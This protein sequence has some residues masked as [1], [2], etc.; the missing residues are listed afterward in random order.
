MVSSEG[1][2]A[3]IVNNYSKMSFNFGP[4]LLSWMEKYSP[5]TLKGIQEAD[6]LS[7]ER[8]SGH[9]SA[10]AQVYNHIIMPLASD[11][12][13]ETQIKW[14]I[15]D[16][17][18]RFNRDPEGMWL[19]E[20][21]VDTDTLEIL[22]E[23][24]IKFTVLAPRQAKEIKEIEDDEWLEVNEGNL[25]T[26][27]AYLCELPSGRTINLFFYDGSISQSIA[28]GG[29]LE[30]GQ[31]LAENLVDAFDD[32]QDSQLVHIATDG[33]SYGHHHHNGDMAMAYCM[34]Y[35]EKNDLAKITNYGEFL[36]KNPPNFQ[37]KI[38]ENSSW[39]CSH[40]VERW[41][42]DCGCNA[43]RAGWNQEW[44]KPLREA[45][46]FLRDSSLEIFEKNGSKY[47]K[48]PREA[49]NA[50]IEIILD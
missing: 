39:S 42:N 48:D 34:D 12:D 20:T 47:L 45:L 21:A 19:A 36:E 50:Y 15:K 35:I 16:F 18:K 3:D 46:D 27:V 22:A 38:N 41:R 5:D 29:L 23:N 11:L 32:N 40:G 33:E 24:N 14:G 43:G 1:K 13:K 17:Q 44:R 28:F 4:T 37:A 49:R 6:K 26:K 25:D 10:M 9:G 8:F 7:Q 2:I 31:K 30:S